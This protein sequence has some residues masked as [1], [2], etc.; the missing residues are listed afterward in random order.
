MP[1][2]TPKW[3][4]LVAACAL[5][6]CGGN[7][8]VSHGVAEAATPA[9]AWQNV[10][11]LNLLCLVSTDRAGERERI[12]R[13][14]CERVRSLSSRNAPIPVSG[15]ALGDP[16]ILD[17]A[18]VTLLV[19]AAVQDA[20]GD[21]LLVFSLRSYR[22]GGTDHDILF[23]AAP[24]AVSLSDAKAL[25]AALQEALAETLPWLTRSDGLRP[26]R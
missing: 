5:A 19:H 16:A 8:S 12:E 25:D 24:R 13:S 2:S 7:S 1:S 4:W 22:P 9:L 3:L 10:T 15:I 21:R 23:G 26:I 6:A 17:A 14:L 20:G 11:R 18:G